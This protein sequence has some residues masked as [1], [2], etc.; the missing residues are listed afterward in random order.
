MHKLWETD[1]N[2]GGPAAETSSE[3]FPYTVGRVVFTPT[4]LAAFIFLGSRSSLRFAA[5]IRMRTMPLLR[6]SESCLRGSHGVCGSHG[7]HG[8]QAARAAG[9]IGLAHWLTLAGALT[10][11]VA[12]GRI[13]SA[14]DNSPAAGPQAPPA[15]LPSQPSAFQPQ[16]ISIGEPI[17]LPS[18]TPLA[19][20][21]PGRFPNP[22]AAVPSSL[23]FQPPAQ[24]PSIVVPPTSTAAPSAA[25]L[26]VARPLPAA[27]DPAAID[28]GLAPQPAA[29]GNGWL[30]IAVDDTVVTG[31]LVVVE[32][33]PGG[34]AD[35][36]GVRPQDVLLAINGNQLQNGDE[37][38]AA[39]A[40][41]APGQRVKMAVGRESRIEDVVALASVRPTEALSRDWQ[42]STDPSSS[43]V[44]VPQVTVPQVTVPQVTVPRATVPQAGAPQMAVAP[45]Q[46][47]PE[48]VAVQPLPAPAAVMPPRPLDRMPAAA[49]SLTVAE[50]KPVSES[51]SI[52]SALPTPPG[53]TALGVRTVPVDPNVQSRFRL[54]DPQ[55]AFVIGV[56][57]DLPAAR[58]GVPPGSV[59]VAINHQPVRSPQELTDLV[60]SG[61]VGRPVP[62]HYVLPG[63]QSKQADVVLQSLEQPLE[64]ALIGG[65]DNG[66]TVEPQVLQPAAQT[67]RRVQPTAGFQPVE[68]DPL[69]RLEALLRR[70]NSR[71]EQMERRLERIEPRR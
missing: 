25:P 38:A 53:R 39:L 48:I 20:P 24:L 26:P 32:V 60:A 51:Y 63:G 44:T 29:T 66:P 62:I 30:G 61:P 70:M 17:S 12:G 21:A 42:S 47:I 9:L 49:P 6:I 16:D 52:P 34:P 58:A 50:S 35:K 7:S 10:A 33:A 15:T 11:S 54:T 67:T 64:R 13:L 28:T 40:A 55:G 3:K 31:R 4:L 59:I 18:A 57:Q 41:I 36:A 19:T 22:P 56:V 68:P 65:G 69:E 27:I 45:T 23:P 71:L 43:Q 5:R 8:I 2:S 14:A 1:E 37:L 46:L